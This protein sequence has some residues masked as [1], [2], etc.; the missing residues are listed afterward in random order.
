MEFTL[1]YT[2]AKEF[3]KSPAHYLRYKTAP[4]EPT[5]AMEF[6]VAFHQYVLEPEEFTKNY[7]PIDDKDILK[8][9]D[10]YQAPRMT[11]KYKEWL[12][13]E[14][15]KAGEKKLLS[16]LDMH[17]IYRMSDSVFANKDAAGL[18]TSAVAKEQHITAEI[19]GVTFNAYID[20]LHGAHVADLKTTQ[21]AHPKDFGKDAANLMY[22]LQGAIYC[23]LTSTRDFY[24]IAVEKSEPYITQVY[25]LDAEY[26]EYGRQLLRKIC[27][28]FKAWDGQAEG[29]STQ[30]LY[31]TK[32]NW[33]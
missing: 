10:S 7:H 29:Y 15:A 11:K 4:K 17:T 24:F 5:A 31:L 23:E 9:L 25:K 3:Y 22:Y 33:L 28:D 30:A 14:Q 21:S 2:S 1:S 16:S 32:P 12:A 26:L 27:E 20:V 13:E 18:I 19:H 8:D 6:G